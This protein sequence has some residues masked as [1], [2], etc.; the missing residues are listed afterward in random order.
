LGAAVTTGAALF[1]FL[2]EA[3]APDD[4]GKY[5]AGHRYELIVFIRENWAE[6]AKAVF[7]TVLSDARW[8]FP[9]IKEIAQVD[10]KMKLTRRTK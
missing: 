5:V 3:T 6:N 10:G 9:H 1:S 8:T 7:R 4:S 2:A